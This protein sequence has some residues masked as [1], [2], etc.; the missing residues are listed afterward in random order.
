MMKNNTI[1][2]GFLLLL[3]QHKFPYLFLILIFCCLPSLQAQKMKKFPIQ[4]MIEPIDYR[5]MHT[6]VGIPEGTPEGD[7][8]ADGTFATAALERTLP[9]LYAPASFAWGSSIA[10]WVV[11]RLRFNPE[12][13]IEVLTTDG[14]VSIAATTPDGYFDLRIVVDK[15]TA[16]FDIYFDNNHIGSGQEFA[17][18]MKQIVF[19]SNEV[20]GPTFD[21]RFLDPDTYTAAINI[22]RSDPTNPSIVVPDSLS[23]AVDS[24]IDDP[25][26]KTQTLT[27]TNTGERML[28]YHTAFGTTVFNTPNVRKKSPIDITA[29]AMGAYGVGHSTNTPEKVS[30]TID[31]AA[32]IQNTLLERATTFT[33]SIYYDS[34]ILF[35]E[36]FSGLQTAPYTTAVKFDA[37][38]DFTLTA[39]RNGFRTETLIAPM[40]LL[41]I[42]KG[43]T[44]PTDGELLL[45]Q[46]I[47][48]TSTE[49]VLRVEQLDTALSFAAGESFWV[50]HKYPENIKFPQGVDDS[51]AQRPD[52]YFFSTDG[53]TT[54]T[55]SGFVFL[56]RALSGQSSINEYLTLEP[57]SGAVAPGTST[58]VTV[59]FDGTLLENGNYQTPILV[60]SNDPQ[61]PVETVATDF[62]VSGQT[63]S[64][65]VTDELLLF[66][67]VF[68]GARAEKTFDITNI[69]LSQLV[70][71]N[72]TTDHPDFAVAESTFT[73]APGATETVTVSFTP[74]R[75]GNSNGILTIASNASNASKISIIVNGVG[76]APPIAV[77]TPDE[78][79]AT[80][81]S[82]TT[83][84]ETMTLRNDGAAPLTYS[85]PD[86]AV[87]KALNNPKVKRNNTAIIAFNDFN[88]NFYG[89]VYDTLFINANGYVAFQIPT[90]TT[91]SNSQ[92]PVDEGNNNII[93]ALWTDLEPQ[94]F[95]GELY[96][97]HFEDRT[98]VQ[99]SDV[100]LYLG[101][102]NETVTFQIVI[103][104]DGNVAI[105]YENVATAPFV[106]QATVGIENAEATDGAQVAFNTDYI[107]DGLALRFVK[108]STPISS[109]ITDVTP[110][111]GVIAAGS[112]QELAVL[113]DATGLNEGVYYDL[114]KVVS[115]APD[116]STSTSLFELNVIGQP[117]IELSTPV[118]EFDPL[119]IGLSSEASFS[120]KN[121]GTK[122]LV[123]ITAF[124]S[125][126][127]SDYSF[128]VVT[129]I[130]LEPGKSQEIFVTFTPTKTGSIRDEL[131]LISDDAFGQDRTS[132]LL[133]GVGVAP[134]IITVTPDGIDLTVNKG[135]AVTEIVT[136]A[137]TGG[138]D[139]IYTLVPPQLGTAQNV[140]Q[141]SKSYERLFFDKIRSK[142][143]LDNRVGPAFLNASGSPG[144]FGYTW[145]DSNSGGPGYDYTD[146]S[147]TGTP[148]VV[149]AD[150]HETIEIPFG[151]NFYGQSFDE[152]T[153][154]A[155]GFLTFAPVVG[156][157][158]I[159]LQIP[160]ATNPDLFIAPLWSDIEPQNGTGIFYQA[161]E[162][163]VIVQYENVPGYGFST[164]APDPVSFQVI[165][166]R[167]GTFKM[168]YANVNSTL[169]T[170]STVGIEGPMGTSGL[171]VV[172][173]SE[174][175]TDEL[176]ITF[177]PPV[178]GS[179]APG[180]SVT[181]P[182]SIATARLEGDQTYTSNVMVYSNDPATPEITI[183]VQ[184]EVLSVPEI[185]GFTLVNADTDQEIE[186]LNNGDV[187]DLE[188]YETNNFNII[189]HKGTK[190]IGS[191]VFDFNKT[192]GYRTENGVPYSLGGDYIGD[193]RPVTLPIGINKITANPYSGA[194]A[195][196]T[197]GIPMMINF[198]VVNS[199]LPA[200]VGFTLVNADTNQTIGSLNTGTVVD[201]NAL[202]TSN[203]NVIAEINENTTGSV[204]FD[205]NLVNGYRTERV[206][207]YTLGGDIAG[208]YKAVQFPMGRNRLSAIAYTPAPLR[209]GIHYD[210]YF[211]VIAGT[212]TSKTP[213]VADFHPNPV[214]DR[215]NFSIKNAENN[216]LE[217]SLVNLLGYPILHTSDFRI[218]TNNQV[219]V[220]MSSIANGTYILRVLNTRNGKVSK[221][222]LVKE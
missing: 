178:T 83:T 13:D 15:D 164:P 54:Y 42:Y 132:V 206:A 184:L 5:D 93:A 150:G 146:I 78:V 73:I 14:L 111:S 74:S 219:T 202:G 113:L 82:N 60:N 165:L 101:N 71:Y 162:E 147:A 97:A 87:V 40:I 148:V 9:E 133:D 81:L 92:I 118:L 31:Q 20:A 188:N 157:N 185:V 98:I 196:G 56:V 218:T 210:I 144:T 4:P 143:T 163:Y 63:S 123:V 195:S 26:I 136:I 151:F 18:V 122:T 24:T 203:F 220:N 41:E 94:N 130:T 193:F 152:V 182:I 79:T 176:A 59:T 70:V 141:Q 3:I 30:N 117:Q 173:N 102:E 110:L 108:P 126:D 217:I 100:P 180:E 32:I 8:F 109:L 208:N 169:S 124:Q 179:V 11:T 77:L 181:V 68:L 125:S 33:D 72:S 215:M 131:V 27:I 75:E 35:P 44:I 175:L 38:N 145:T 135:E 16:N 212:P 149:D 205:F 194:N 67:N 76:V 116:K 172:F 86:L 134:P 138:A 120:V 19:L 104:A 155:N 167:D 53:G 90:G 168:Q 158:Y 58:E 142:E 34:G 10:D 115:N 51:V 65:Q 1:P 160:D 23:T 57:S 105:F 137:N 21:A 107:K 88:T 48:H 89:T 177:T 153:I 49:G 66:A 85:F 6:H 186:A 39:I 166:Y 84:A 156:N 7:L 198:E 216:T 191:V 61:T 29:L 103:N 199:R 91:Y 159:N 17:T 161:T 197:L 69:G 174:F 47:D 128:D 45:S 43:G 209:A 190:T 37:E 189:A 183:P 2:N 207:P 114:L 12:A 112:S 28:E 52:T 192:K 99:W 55:P 200:V 211:D 121:I 96:V 25:A 201:I 204:V 170:T 80:V 22:A 140:H 214:K 213:L 127:D 50:V 129:P 64:I 139:L 221:T 36:N 187:I 222:L 95:N 46:A 171:Q 154:G 62:R 106:N 119:F